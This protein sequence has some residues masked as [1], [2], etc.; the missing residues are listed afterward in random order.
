[1]K[2]LIYQWGLVLLMSI[3]SIKS[4]ATELNATNDNKFTVSGYIKDKN[5]GETLIGANVYIK[6]LKTG[7]AANLYGFYSMSLPQ[8]TYTFVYSY[9]GYEPITLEINLT[10]NKTINMELISTQSTMKEVVIVG[11]KENDNITNTEMSMVKLD[12]KTISKIPVLMGESDLIKAIQLLPGV[13]SSCEGSSGFN[14]RGGSAD[15]NLILLDE[16]TVY[17]ASHL[18]GF[19]SVFNSDAIKDVKLYKGDIPPS[20][21]GRLSSLLDVRMKDG[22]NKKYNV[23]GGIGLIASRLTLE[24]PIVKDKSSF[25]VSGRRTYFDFFLPLFKKKDSAMS[26]S[27]LYFYDLNLKV[28]Y[29][30]NKNNRIFVSGYF[31]RDLFRYTNELNFQWGNNTET[32]RWNH[33]FGTKMFSNL[34]ML[35]SEY[36]YELGSNSGTPKFKWQS[37]MKDVSLKYDFNYY[38]NTNNTLKYGAA[39]TVH[40][41]N[42]GV[43]SIKES[44]DEYKLPKTNALEYALYLSNEQKLGALLTIDYGLRYSIFQNMG[45]A[46]LNRYDNNYNYKDSVVYAKGKIFNTY[47]GFEP[48]I[49]GSYLLNE[50]SSIKGAYSKTRQYVQLAS[51]STG[52][53]P[54][55]VWFPA[56]PNVKPQISDQFN[57]GYFRNF[58][59][60]A[61]E[62]SIEAY[63]KKMKNQVDFKDYANLLLNDKMD[64]DLR[65]GNARS[66]GTEI[67]IKKNTG[68]LTGWV[69][70]TL[71]RA[72]KK[73]NTINENKKYLANY[74]HTHNVSVVL[75]YAFGKR[76]DVSANWVYIT[77]APTTL[78]TGRFYYG[79]TII[80]VYS[81]K[82]SARMPDYHRLD[83]SITLRGKEKPGQ[84]FYGEWNLSV[85]NV[86]NRKNAYSI[87]FEQNEKNPQQMQA[88]K[89]SM[90]PIVPSITYNF[91]F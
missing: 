90:F 51:N 4:M 26:E 69:S 60:N 32:I 73:I 53:S 55:D 49:S 9:I 85:F 46:T 64:G 75:T 37:D 29:E 77:G 42:P 31:G 38:L 18:M 10:E 17:N 66:Y 86:Y 45:K 40:Y 63:Y 76:V 11:K 56:S 78:P 44:K 13:Q 67:M 79:N 80:P 33:L 89:M 12:N 7:A 62:T 19:F 3:C 24:G 68:K 83:L 27:K 2:K 34:T 28:N 39:G 84:K 54:L 16:A 47:S 50:V 22:N 30:I 65:F 71:S 58:D 74:D 57:I 1:M 25:M 91:H 52:G 48:R 41:F 23:S 36:N 21:G 20:F 15:Q 59:K 5:T 70:Y 61:Y 6:E 88:Y 14:V 82:N 81:D 8:G 72:E 43:F 35:Y 87:F